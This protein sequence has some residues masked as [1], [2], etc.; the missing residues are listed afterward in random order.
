MT[1]RHSSSFARRVGLG[2][3][4]GIGAGILLVGVGVARIAVFLL[5]G[6]RLAELEADDVRIL[7]FYVGG[8][9]AGG[10]LIGALRPLLRGKGGV[11]VGCMLAGIVVMLAIAIG[12]KGR[13]SA[14]DGVDWVA[15]PLMGMVFGSAAAYGFTRNT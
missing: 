1:P 14:L 7:V 8:F 3:L 9:G 13:L 15:M 4:L 12:D 5:S 2:A 11:Y 10:A 6:G